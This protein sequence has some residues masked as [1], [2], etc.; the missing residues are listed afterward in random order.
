MSDEAAV[1]IIAAFGVRA[2]GGDGGDPYFDEELQVAQV[3]YSH[4]LRRFKHEHPE[5]CGWGERSSKH[6]VI[7][8]VRCA[9]AG[10][11]IPAAEKVASR[12][13]FDMPWAV[14]CC[15]ADMDARDRK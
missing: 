2:H 14:A 10:H 3:R 1:L 6:V 15:K 12:V 9:A 8:T 11:P 5:F 13:G 4:A 7:W